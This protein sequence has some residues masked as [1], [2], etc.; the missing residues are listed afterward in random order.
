[1][2]ITVEFLREEL[3]G[4]EAQ[5]NEQ[6]VRFQQAL[7]ACGVLRQLIAHAEKPEPDN[8]KPGKVDDLADLQPVDEKP[9]KVMKTER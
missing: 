6:G 9:K 8:I 4:L 5:A 3:K 1:M 7:G 2:E